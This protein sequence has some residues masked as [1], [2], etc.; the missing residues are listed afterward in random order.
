MPKFKPGDPKPP[1]SGRKKGTPNKVTK[2]L[3]KAAR[4]YTQEALEALVDMVRDPD[5]PSV[6]LGAAREILDR[7]HG[8]PRTTVDATVSAGTDAQAIPDAALAHRINAL[9][10]GADQP[11]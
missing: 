9:L 4:Q 8:K 11:N 2:D 7:G 5:N 10:E 1:G 3:A 6:R